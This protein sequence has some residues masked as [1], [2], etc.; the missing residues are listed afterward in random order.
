MNSET[1]QESSEHTS[2]YGLQYPH[3]LLTC[4]FVVCASAIYYQFALL[5]P[6]YGS[7]SASTQSIRQ[8]QP[9]CL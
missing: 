9:R 1:E 2:G 6:L 4:Y 8:V 3:T 7:G 5:M